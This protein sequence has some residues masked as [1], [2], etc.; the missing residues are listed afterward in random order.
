PLAVVYP[1][2]P[3]RPLRLREEGPAV[4][5]AQVDLPAGGRRVQAGHF[6]LIAV[7][8]E[9]LAAVLARFQDRTEGRVAALRGRVEGDPVAVEKGPALAARRWAVVEAD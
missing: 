6:F 3:E 5:V 1:T 4:R 7:A 8:D 2:C 9:Q